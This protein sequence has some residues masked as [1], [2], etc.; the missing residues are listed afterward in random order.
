MSVP[1]AS[2]SVWLGT[3]RQQV[4]PIPPNTATIGRLPDNWLVLSHPAIRRQHAEIEVCATDILLT[5]LATSDE[6]GQAESPTSVNG[7]RLLPHTPVILHDGDAI[8]IE[9]FTFRFHARVLPEIPAPAALMAPAHE[10]RAAPLVSV[11]SVPMPI[12][13]GASFCRKT[14]CA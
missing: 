13:H 11:E 2:L 9:P 14:G 6:V 5:D 1:T 3:T 10:W 7:K 12:M 8:T 4:V